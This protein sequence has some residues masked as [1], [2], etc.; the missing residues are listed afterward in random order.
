MRALPLALVVAL[1]LLAGCGEHDR[2][3]KRV[4]L[5]GAGLTGEGRLV[6]IGGGRSLLIECTGTGSPTV[7]L[8]AGYGGSSQNWSQVAPALG[9]TTRTCAYDRAGLGSSLPM[10][11]VHDAGDEIRDLDRLLRAA[12]IPPPYVLVGHSYGGLLVRLFAG[13]HPGDTAAV[14]LVDAMGRDQTRRQLRVWPRPVAPDVRRQ[15]ATPVD[16]GVD[17]RAGEA[18]AAR[19]H[20]LGSVPLA[21]VT[22]ATHAQ[23]WGQLPASLGRVFDRLWTPMQDELARLSSNHVHVVALRSDHFV[24]GVDGQ[25]GVVIRAVDAVVR[26]ARDGAPL[27]AC[28]QL[29]HGAGV[30]CRG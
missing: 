13:A 14:V 21:V 23:A 18:L 3:P 22:A 30:R 2:T 11:G 25:P 28:T 4:G 15:F 16:S 20:S 1:L 26:A 19:V 6:D 8:E 5:T 17:L 7:V 9:H 29:F 27:P 12:R 10:P 24:Q